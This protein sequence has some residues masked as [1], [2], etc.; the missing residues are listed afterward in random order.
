MKVKVQLINVMQVFSLTSTQS[1]LRGPRAGF[2]GSLAIASRAAARARSSASA[3]ATAASAAAVSRGSCSCLFDLHLRL[4]LHSFFYSIE[5]RAII[6]S[7]A[8]RK[9]KAQ[10]LLL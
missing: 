1:D 9:R 3:S 4:T 5:S 7:A 2:G 8:R 10:Y 6:I